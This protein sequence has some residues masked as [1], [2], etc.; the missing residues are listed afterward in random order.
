VFYGELIMTNYGLI[1]AFDIN[2]VPQQSDEFYQF[3]YLTSV[4]PE[5]LEA[6][7]QVVVPYKVTALRSLEQQDATGGGCG[8]YTKCA[9]VACKSNC[10]TGVSVTDSSSCVSVSYG[11]CGGQGFI[12]P[13]RPTYGDGG[14]IYGPGGGGGGANDPLP[15]GGG[16]PRCRAGGGD[17]GNQRGGGTK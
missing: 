5:S 11:S 4:V 16:F 6:K 14:P 12:P 7:E 3:E 15:Q 8:V 10:P 2:F 1:R 17:C 13:Y 9:S